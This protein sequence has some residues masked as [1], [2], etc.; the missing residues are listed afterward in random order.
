MLDV[1]GPGAAPPS[2]A[3]QVCEIVADQL[4]LYRRLRKAYQELDHTVNL[5]AFSAAALLGS[6]EGLDLQRLVYHHYRDFRAGIASG[7]FLTG[8]M[9]VCPCSM[10]TLAA[11]PSASMRRIRLEARSLKT[12]TATQPPLWRMQCRSRTRRLLQWPVP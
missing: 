10:G 6:V 11:R 9:A 8:G 12:R 3:R 5:D 2:N 4:G 1:F 7:S